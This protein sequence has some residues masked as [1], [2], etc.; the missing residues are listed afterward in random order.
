MIIDCHGH[1][2]TAPP[3][4]R[5]VARPADRR[6]HRPGPSAPDAAADLR[7][8]DDELRREHRAEPA[9]AHGRARHRPHG[10]LAAGVLHGPPRRRLR[11]PPPSGRPS[12]TSSATASASSTRSASSPP[13]CSRSRPASTRP[14]ASRSS[15]A[16][17]RSSVPSRSNLQ[18]GPVRRPLDGPAADGPLLVPGLREDGRVRHPGDGPRQHQ[19]QPG[20]PHHRRALPQRRHHRVH[21]A[22]PGRP[23]RRLPDPAA[24]HPARRRRRPVPLGPLPGPGHG[25]GEASRWRNTCWATSSST[26][27]ST[28]SPASTSCSTSYPP[29]TSSSPRR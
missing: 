14:P 17:S 11:R 23:V 6:A 9:A 5:R 24:G 16:A 15:P 26:P 18:P 19:R 13:R 10:L 2:T 28:T 7:I 1:Y 27:A 20:L 25:A 8:S 12:A 21:A 22:D 3:A 29:A 4:L